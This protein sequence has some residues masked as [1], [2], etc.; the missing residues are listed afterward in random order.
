MALNARQQKFGEVY[1]GDAA[2]AAELAGYAGDRNTLAVTG[3][4]LLKNPEVRALIDARGGTP[5]PTNGTSA[6]TSDDIDTEENIRALVEIRDNGTTLA[7]HRIAA[8]ERLEQIK[9]RRYEREQAAGGGDVLERQR[10]ATAA[11]VKAMRERERESGCCAR[12]GGPIG[13]ER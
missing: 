2:R 6:G 5:K 11:A 12:C 8:V 10:A 13:G 9:R 1:E 3:H 7:S 4:R